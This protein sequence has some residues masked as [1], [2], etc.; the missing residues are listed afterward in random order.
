VIDINPG[1]YGIRPYRI[2][3]ICLCRERVL[4]VPP[5]TTN[6]GKYAKTFFESIGAA[7]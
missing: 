7:M 4:T 2:G 3:T 6:V 5:V 1:G